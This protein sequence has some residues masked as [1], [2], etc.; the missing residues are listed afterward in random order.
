MQWS[1]AGAG[2]AATG[3]V[4]EGRSPTQVGGNGRWPSVVGA[5][6]GGL[7]L[8]WLGYD[9][10]GPTACGTNAEPGDRE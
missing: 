10:V 2:P 9:W 1:R 4:T 6:G 8:V 3:A 5:L 7:G